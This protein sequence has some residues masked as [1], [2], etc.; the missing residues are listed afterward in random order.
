ML[1]VVYQ[2]IDLGEDGRAYRPAEV[3]FTN[4]ADAD[5]VSKPWNYNEPHSRTLYVMG[6]LTDYEAWKHD[7]VRKEALAKLTPEE[8]SALG[9]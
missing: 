3:V 5:E 9:I 2:P 4:E 1:D 7:E 6:N 8:R